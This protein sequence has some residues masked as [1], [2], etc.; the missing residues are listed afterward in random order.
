MFFP[1]I[2]GTVFLASFKTQLWPS[3]YNRGC[4]VAVIFLNGS[5]FMSY[6][7]IT[8][9]NEKQVLAFFENCKYILRIGVKYIA[10]KAVLYKNIINVMLSR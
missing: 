8:K 2:Q 7:N 3:Q 10:L 9:D 4:L 1:C 6:S 5:L